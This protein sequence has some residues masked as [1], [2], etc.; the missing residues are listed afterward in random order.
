MRL[1]LP[2]LAC[3]LA[4]APVSRAADLSLPGPFTA[5]RRD[6]TVVRSGGST[7]TATV[8]YPATAATVGAPFDASAGPCPVIAF[9]HEIGRAHV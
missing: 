3:L 9:G 6:Q 1:A 5:S 2:A 7:F 4:L 8:H